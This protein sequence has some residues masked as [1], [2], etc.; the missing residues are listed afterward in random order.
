V[1]REEVSLQTIRLCGALNSTF[2]RYLDCVEKIVDARK[3]EGLYRYIRMRFRI[4]GG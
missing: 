4:E 2:L 1:Q 3:G